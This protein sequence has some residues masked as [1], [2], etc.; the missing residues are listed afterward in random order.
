MV[1]LERHLPYDIMPGIDTAQ[2]FRQPDTVVE[3]GVE[4]LTFHFEW[5]PYAGHHLVCGLA[6]AAVCMLLVEGGAAVHEALQGRQVAG[7]SGWGQIAWL[8]TRP[9]AAVG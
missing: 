7:G 2:V 3:S 8:P 1:T 9:G 6:A 4:G 5:E